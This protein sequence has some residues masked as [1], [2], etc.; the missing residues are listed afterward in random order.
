[1]HTEG[2]RFDSAHLHHPKVVLFLKKIRKICQLPTGQAIKKGKENT[3]FVRE[4]QPKLVETL[5]INEGQRGESV[6]LF[7]S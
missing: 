5:L 1:L 6:W 2:Q 4:C 3:D 7:K